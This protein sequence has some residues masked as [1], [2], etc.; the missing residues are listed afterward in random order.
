ML[1]ADVSIAQRILDRLNQDLNPSQLGQLFQ[2]YQSYKA[3][4]QEL[5]CEREWLVHGRQ[6]QLME[7]KKKIKNKGKSSGALQQQVCQTL[8]RMG[9][10]FQQ[11]FLDQQLAREIDVKLNID[12]EKVALVLA[13][14]KSIIS[15][16]NKLLGRCVDHNNILQK[17]GGWRVE[18]VPY[19]EFKS[20]KTTDEQIRYLRQILFRNSEPVNM[21]KQ[22]P[23][24]MQEKME[25][26]GK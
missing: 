2:A 23:L 16:M 11:S 7:V 21:L 6:Q 15:N 5:R 24:Q 3:H 9:V 4:G 12:N 8:K 10:N 1:S 25:S 20:L 22:I 17:V 14:Y 18:V 26:F 19:F 13:G